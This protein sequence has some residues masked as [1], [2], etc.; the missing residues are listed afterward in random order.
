M[1]LKQSSEENTFL[2]F[3][4]YI[5]SKIGKQPVNIPSGTTVNVAGD[6]ITVA[7]SKG[8]L[9][10]TVPKGIKV[11]VEGD[12]AIVSQAKENDSL[13]R[14]L[15][16]LTRAVIANMVQGVDKGFEKKLELQGVGYRAQVQGTD[17]VL[18]VGFAHQVKIKPEQG[19]TFSVT[20]NVITVAGADKVTV[21][22]TAARIRAVRPPEPYKGK[23][24]RYV[25]ERVRRK[26]GKVAKAVGAK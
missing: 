20:E 16:G 22:D 2:R 1:Q 7:G 6:N 12:N 21:G 4:K 26:A 25:G 13:T 9:S 14:S 19:I 10:F 17:L 24:I 11:V 8:E 18:N 15:Y 3:G 5:M 23:G